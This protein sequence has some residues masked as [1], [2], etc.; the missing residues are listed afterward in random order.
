[1]QPTILGLSLGALFGA[2]CRSVDAPLLSEPVAQE[3]EVPPAELRQLARRGQA[4]LARGEAAQVLEL[5][6]DLE[7][8]E[9]CLTPA[10]ITLRDEAHLL[11]AFERGEI[12]LDENIILLPADT[13]Q[14]RQLLTP[15]D[16]GCDACRAAPSDT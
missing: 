3:Q 9:A 8:R 6:D 15:A 16:C 4:L 7:A 1:M 12:S 2:G 10:F 5:V 13:E 14:P 11:L